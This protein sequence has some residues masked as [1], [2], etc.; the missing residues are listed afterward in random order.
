M[1]KVKLSSNS[2]SRILD[3]LDYVH[4]T[5]I[6]DILATIHVSY[7]DFDPEYDIILNFDSV[8]AY[9]QFVLTYGEYF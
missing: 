5:K 2:F 4:G 6:E 8:T 7:F 1:P 9:S 3:S